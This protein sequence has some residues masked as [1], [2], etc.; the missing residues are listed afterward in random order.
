[1][2]QEFINQPRGR[3][4]TATP[5]TASR[6]S[7]YQFQDISVRPSHTNHCWDNANAMALACDILSTVHS[8]VTVT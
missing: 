8:I 6:D 7:D 1:M 5:T 3:W 2:A 4:Q